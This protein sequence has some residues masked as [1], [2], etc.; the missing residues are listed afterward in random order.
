MHCHHGLPHVGGHLQ[1]ARLLV[2]S[3]G[4]KF[5]GLP[6]GLAAISEELSAGWAQILAYKAFYEVSQDQ[7][8]GPA[9]S[10]GHLEDGLIDSAW[11]D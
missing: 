3:L 10:S 4:I 5:A 7:S 9:A 11:G 6:Y 2:S 8:P 1:A